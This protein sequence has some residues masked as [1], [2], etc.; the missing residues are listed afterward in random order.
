M[1]VD[2][3]PEEKGLTP[4]LGIYTTPALTRAIPYPVQKVYG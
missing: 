3:S 2:I 1:N 4:P